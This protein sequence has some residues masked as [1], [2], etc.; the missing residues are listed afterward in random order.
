[1]LVIINNKKTDAH[2]VWPHPHVPRHQPKSAHQ[3]QYSHELQSRKP[4][5]KNENEKL[6]TKS[7][8]EN[9]LF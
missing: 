1:M 7:T 8:I 4:E 2:L 9:L 3:I 6:K 5:K